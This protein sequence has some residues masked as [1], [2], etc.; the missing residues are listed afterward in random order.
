MINKIYKKI[1][2]RY[3]ELFKFIF[4]LRYLF[5]IFFMSI[6]IFLSIP[7]FFDFTKKDEDIKKYLLE[8]Y[9]L[10][11][12]SYDSVKYRSFPVPRL[13]IKNI[14]I[15]VG[16]DLIQLKVESLNI[17]L[18]LINI[19]NYKNFK[20]K[21]IVL[22]NNKIS[23]LDSNLKIFIHYIYNLKKKISFKNSLIKIYKKDSPLMNIE[24]I[25]FS[26]YGYNKN[27]VRGKLFD[28]KFKIVLS[29]SYSKINFQ[30]LN[31]GI[32]ADINFNKIRKKNSIINGVFK[33]KLLNSKLKF[34]FDLDSNQ[35]KIYNSFF[36]NKD[37]S[38]SNV[39][40]IT[41]HPFLYSSSIIRLE[42]INIKLFNNI[43][44]NT[45]LNSKELIKKI[46]TKNEIIFK[47]KNF[48]SHLIEVLNLN[49]NLS[50]GRLVY[51]NEI[52]N[53]NTSSVCKGNIN[54]LMEY[55]VLYFD[56]SI[57]SKDKKKFLKKFSIK[58]KN[59]NELLKIYVKGNLNIF[60][61]KIN[62]KKIEMNQDYKATKEDLY[63]FKE[64]FE[65]MFFDQGFYGIFRSEKIKNFILA[66]S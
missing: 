8:S 61:N 56:C 65:N 28:K 36:R 20:A 38:F 4:F 14:D 51:L 25:N 7:Y 49:I 50:Y 58:Y 17:Y 22:N 30:L 37:L 19:Y 62:F 66:I 53:S 32:N 47:P 23:L 45:I 43:N 60:N 52:K 63:Y 12:S 3:S 5:A 15:V 33:S 9:G 57:A 54:L 21:K 59:K 31:T 1:H 40:N 55:P 42:E 16:A 41:Y 24:K 6:V 44:I 26:N 11:L 34:D 10:T 35:L 2:N 64:L 48:G 18:K 13:E 39:T 46:N 27:I 29:D